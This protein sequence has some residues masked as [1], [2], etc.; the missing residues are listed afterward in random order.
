MYDSIKS[1]SLILKTVTDS[2]V[3]NLTFDFCPKAI[4]IMI[5]KMST[6]LMSRLFH[7]NKDFD[8][9]IFNKTP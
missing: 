3:L 1:I 2:D 5:Y 4:A 9:L 6:K 7:K 8:F